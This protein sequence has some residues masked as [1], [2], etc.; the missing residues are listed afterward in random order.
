MSNLINHVNVIREKV[1]AGLARMGDEDLVLEM[2]L[3]L[4]RI[5]ELETALVPFARR[6]VEAQRHGENNE[7]LQ[8]YAKECMNAKNVLDPAMSTPIAYKR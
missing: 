7:L 5:D 3:L 6:A 1:N 8:V 2:P 4:K